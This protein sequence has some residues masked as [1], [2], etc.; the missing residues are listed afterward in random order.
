[1]GPAGSVERAGAVSV[2]KEAPIPLSH[3][4]QERK[5]SDLVMH[6]IGY[7]SRPDG[8]WADATK[9]SV[10]RREHLRFGGEAAG[11]LLRPALLSVDSDLEDPAAGFAQG[12]VGLWLA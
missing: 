2:L 11:F 1:V 7:C 3:I 5:S 9:A 4:V 12:D 8:S 10:D 6:P